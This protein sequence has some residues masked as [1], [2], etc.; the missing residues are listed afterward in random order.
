MNLYIFENTRNGEGITLVHTQKALIYRI[1]SFRFYST[2]HVLYALYIKVYAKCKFDYI[3]FQV[4][5][6]LIIIFSYK[7]NQTI[8]QITSV[9]QIN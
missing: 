2:I 9:I 8:D 6:L 5:L 3:L 1:L 4:I 7:Q